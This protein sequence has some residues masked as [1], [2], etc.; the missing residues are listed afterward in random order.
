MQRVIEQLKIRALAAVQRWRAARRWPAT[1]RAMFGVPAH[2]RALWRLV[3]PA[4][5]SAQRRLSGLLLLT[6]VLAGQVT[7]VPA[8]WPIAARGE[9][10]AALQ[11]VGMPPQSG[12]I[13]PVV[14]R[15]PFPPNVARWRGLVELIGAE[16]QVEEELLL[17]VIAQ[18]SDG[19]PA[20]ISRAGA[21]GLM[22]VM[23]GTF[24]EVLPAGDL[25]LAVDNIRAGARYL[26]RSLDAHGDL[27]WALAGYNA[28]IE[29]TLRLRREVGYVPRAWARGEPFQ[30]M[31]NVHA[32][33]LEHRGQPDPGDWSV[34]PAHPDRG[35]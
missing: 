6:I 35:R 11:S 26:R 2:A 10:A 8:N 21:Q 18:E 24:K 25:T 20:R 29:A 23:P 3:V 19:V 13:P 30:Y 16:E 27:W 5:A 32:C 9:V 17:C 15:V 14:S 33:V 1:D 28:G 22:Q 12:D 34:A 4:T 7:A 31:H